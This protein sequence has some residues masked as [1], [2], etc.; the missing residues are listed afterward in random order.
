MSI[1]AGIDAWNKQLTNKQTRT[2][3]VSEMTESLRRYYKSESH[4]EDCLKR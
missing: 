2:I 3:K 4:G 1:D